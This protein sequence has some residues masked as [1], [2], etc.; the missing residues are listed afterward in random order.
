MP[1]APQMLPTKLK[2]IKFFILAFFLGLTATVLGQETYLDNF[3]TT[4]Y[5]NNNGT[6]NFTSGW[7]ETNETTSATGGR[8]RVN[9]SQLRIREMDN[10][11]I[12]RTLDLSGASSVTL[13]LDY[14]RTSGNESVNVQLYNGSTYSTVATLA[15]TGSLNY[16]LAANEISS[17][18]GIRF[19]TGSGGWGSSETMYIDNVLFTAVFNPTITIADISVDEGAGTATFTATHTGANAS[20][21]FTVNYQTV[22]GSATSGS[23]YTAIASGTLNF[24]GTSGDTE[25]IAVNITDDSTV[26]NLETFSIQFTGSSD[27]SVDYSDTA[28]G[29]I[30][31]N[32]ALIITDGNTENTCSVTFF[33]SG[34]VSGDYTDDEYIEFTICPDVVG[35]LVHLNFTSFDVEDGY[36]Y[37]Y[38]Y[39]GT[40]TGGTLIG[41]YHN[42][43][44]PTTITSSDAS[45]CLTFLFDSDGS[46]QGTGWE[47][48][49]SCVVPSPELVI[50]DVA[51]DEDAGTATFTVTHTG[52]DASGSFSANYSITAGTA[53]Q[54]VDYTTGSGLYT[55]TLNF[56]GTSGDT[57]QITIL[58]TDDFD[59][60]PDETY[61]IQFTSVTDGSVDITDT[62][63]GTINN[64]DAAAIIQVNNVT[65]N[66]DSGTATFTVTHTGGDR[67][68][69]FTVDYAITAGTATEGTDYT[70]GSG[71]YTGTLNFNG[72]AGDTDQITVLITD[73]FDFESSETY[74]ISFSATTD[75]SVN[76]TDTA[77][78]TIDDDENIPANAPLTLFEQFNG[79]YDY[80]LTGGSLRDQDNNTNSC[81]VVSSSS[82]TLTTTIPGTATIQKAYLFWAHSGANPD[83]EVTFEGQTVNANFANQSTFGS[84]IHYAMMADV[85]TLISGIADPST[86]TFDFS[87]LTVDAGGSYC[88]S[89]VVMGG[90]S[91]MIFYTE[92][93]LPAVTINLY[94]GFDGEQNNTVSF[95]LSGFYAIGASGAKTT[96]LSWE[97]D[98]TLAN[99]EVLSLTTG[100]GTTKLVGDGDNNGSTVN[101]PFNSTLF[102]DTTVPNVNDATTYGL[103]LDTYDISSLISAGESTATTN[104]GVGQDYVMLNAVL[105]KVPSNLIVGT[106]FEDVNYGGGAGRD[107]ATSSG[108]AVE[109]AIVELYNS[110]GVL[111]ETTTTNAAGEYSFGGMAD[112]D[113]SV[114]VVNTSVTS[115]RGGGSSCSACL[116]VQTFRRNYTTAG[117]FTSITDEI[118]GADPAGVDVAAGI[119]TN[120]Q[121]IS[122]VSISS[123]GVAGLDFGFNFNTIVNTNEDGQGSLE[124]FIV[125]SN[126]LDET[127][128]DI[129]ANAIFDPASGDDTSIFMIPSTTDPL[130]RAADSNFGSGYFDITISNGN[131]LTSITAAN[132]V[133][134]GRTQT[135]YSTDTNSGSVGSG[136]TTVGTSAIVLPNYD[137]PEIQVH[138]DGG[139]VIKI[140]GSNTVVRNLAVFGGNN[141]GI[142]VDNG[143]A[144]ISNN[145]LG[146]NA[147]GA[148]AGNIT[149]GVEII[150]G[151]AVVD[152]N[153][154]ATNT[155]TGIL[156][157][158]GTATTVQNNHITSNGDDSCEDNITILSGSGIVIQRN[159]I[160]NASA[161]GIDGDGITGNLT[162]FEN[163]IT[164]SGQDGGNCSGSIENAGIRLDGSNSSITNNVIASNGGAGIVLAGGN[165]SGNLISQNSIY[166]NGTAVASLGIDLDPSDAVGD[167]VTLND[168]GD[169]DNGPNQSMNFPIITSAYKSGTDLIVSG[170]S[171]PG[172]TLEFFLTDV[173]Q[174]T[175][176]LGDNQLGLST[177]YGEGQVYIGAFTEGG[178]ADTDPGTSS[179]SDVDGNTDNTNRFQCS[180][181]IPI[182]VSFGE[183][184]T[185]TATLSNST[186]EFSPFSKIRAYSVITNRKITYRVNKN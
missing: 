10:R 99:N 168:T 127:G 20:G 79:Y 5:S 83:L 174:G 74:T 150:A 148:N 144:T 88:S 71:L 114:R 116:P 13:T 82:N 81:S 142:R 12:T 61:S 159:L 143:S 164:T 58:I 60:E 78:G 176:T 95:T 104:V 124:Q 62:A 30:T 44:I 139:D 182:A 70:T 41:Q 175:A 69:A 89:T 177:D 51:V 119:L 121:T 108:V 21:A 160:E 92:D 117:G 42:G 6:Q 118:G 19:I 87:G 40:T 67:P 134:D 163:T 100:S 132:T 179:Y 111:R 145:F 64:E 140:E 7:V 43:N 46:V 158:G 94:Q 84:L 101:N 141:T 27:G 102:D 129:E 157:N 96:V 181:P 52:A 155:A 162:I 1:N 57:E 130:G 156:V 14:N 173:N 122:T 154:I 26:E 48:V 172:A 59:V 113:Y 167:G 3:N 135:A 15:G 32:D 4:S 39:E 2:L 34:G 125:N 165:T 131:P 80:A 28:T 25:S 115:S 138:R 93:T 68:A 91:L 170:W 50:A 36:D 45:G 23:D 106:V 22:N 137:R 47:A 123:E 17:A 38:V 186:S 49:V 35:S 149:D 72:T 76:I 107:R 77:T 120:A 75:G 29:S 152:G 105:L 55:G 31:D 171:R 136:G 98:Q 24:N 66:E 183:D 54:G 11:Y 184:I 133:I 9:S 65:V 90:W 126:N 18:S 153:Y 178:A 147:T 151:T 16:V 128:L 169:L 37:L 86:N 97:G 85:T 103:D 33:D 56:N 73:D 161:L 180:I 8:I 110:S 146:V 53:S 112:G 185:A 109:G 63:T 166:A